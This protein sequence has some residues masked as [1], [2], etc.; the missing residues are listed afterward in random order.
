MSMVHAAP[1]ADRAL[2]TA[3]VSALRDLAAQHGITKL[4]F[5]SPGR[6][7][8]HVAGDRDALDISAFELGAAGLLGAELLLYSDA[9]L[10]KP[11]V[12]PDLVSAEPL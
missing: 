4:R 10:A 12:S 9:V 8:G 1:K 7:V 6:L 3:H 11:N 5:A 2:V